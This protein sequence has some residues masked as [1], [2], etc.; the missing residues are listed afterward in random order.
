MSRL[1]S[2]S[3]L[4][5]VTKDGQRESLRPDLYQPDPIGPHWDYRDSS[6]KWWRLYPDGSR[7]SRE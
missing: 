5:L 2:D 1:K 3:R 7:I 4:P 6:G